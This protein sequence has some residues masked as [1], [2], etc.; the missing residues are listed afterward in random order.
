VIVLNHYQ[1]LIVQNFSRLLE[2]NFHFVF[3]AVDFFFIL[4]KYVVKVFHFGRSIHF[5]FMKAK[6]HKHSLVI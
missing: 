2:I 5:H 3:L 6:I 4:S 1:P